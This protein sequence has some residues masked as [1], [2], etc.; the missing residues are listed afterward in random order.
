MPIATQSKRQIL[1]PL[2]LGMALLG[3]S[4]MVATDRAWLSCAAFAF[5][6]T[7]QLVR[8]WRLWRLASLDAADD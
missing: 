3:F 4:V 7:I 2:A 8:A 1:F 6:G 5:L